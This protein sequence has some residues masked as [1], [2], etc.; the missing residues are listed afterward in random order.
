MALV[1]LVLVVVALIL[2]GVGI[3]VGLVAC[4]VA[5]ALLGVG[6]ISSSVFVG[7][8]SGRTATAIRA[9]LLQC[10]FFG[11]IPAGAVSA[12]LAL[13]IFEGQTSDWRIV[14]YGALSG[15]CVGLLIGF[16]LDL[17]SR[18]LQAWAQARLQDSRSES[19][20]ATDRNAG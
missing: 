7:L 8:R 19:T 15:A 16:V 6:V 1:S 5:G 2:I 9:F 4:G 3:A 13:S 20:L 10:G 14:V 12:W 11:G 17:I 18:K